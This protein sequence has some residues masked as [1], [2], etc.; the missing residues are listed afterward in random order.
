MIPQPPKITFITLSITRLFSSN[1]LFLFFPHLNR[2]SV[3]SLCFCSSLFLS[4]FLREPQTVKF[5]SL[6]FQIFSSHPC[7]GLTLGRSKRARHSPC[8]LRREPT[9]P[10]FGFFTSSLV[11][12]SFSAHPRDERVTLFSSLPRFCPPD[13]S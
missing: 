3:S 6:H 12:L 1:I 5:S 9:N 2:V 11:E 8:F 4:L 10:A 13:V 7:L